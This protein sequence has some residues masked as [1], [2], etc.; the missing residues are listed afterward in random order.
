MD[1]NRLAF[2]PTFSDCGRY[3]GRYT[4]YFKTAFSNRKR[5]LHLLFKHCLPAAEQVLL[6]NYNII[7]ANED[8]VPDFLE[9]ILYMYR[10]IDRQIDTYIHKHTYI[11]ITYVKVQTRI[12][13]ITGTYVIVAQHD[14]FRIT[15]CSRLQTNNKIAVTTC[16]LA[17]ILLKNTLKGL[18]LS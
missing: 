9:G 14:T 1:F 17:Y 15:G 10:K 18:G 2:V 5:L 12:R 6:T 7:Q 16:N 11:Q 4:L 8:L 3:T 13:I